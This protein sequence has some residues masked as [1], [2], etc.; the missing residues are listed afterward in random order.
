MEWKE[1]GGNESNIPVLSLD[2]AAT[3]RAGNNLEGLSRFPENRIPWGILR[4]EGSP[5]YIVGIQ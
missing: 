3:M 4:K 1:K 5:A 2:S